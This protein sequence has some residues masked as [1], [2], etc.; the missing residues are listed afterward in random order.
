MKRLLL[1][2]FLIGLFAACTTQKTQEEPY[3]IIVSMDGFRWDYT[4]SVSTPHFDKIAKMGVKA[5]SMKVSFPSKTFPNHYTLVT[6]LVPDNHGIV[7][8]TFYAPEYDEV[9]SI[10][11]REKVQ[12][13]KFYGGEPIW[14]TAEK[15]GVKAASYFWVGSEADIQGIHPSYWKEYDHHFDYYQR[16]DSVIAWLSLEEENRPHMISWYVDQPDGVGHHAGPHSPKADSVIAELDKLLGYFMDRLSNHPLAEHVNVIVT[17]DHGMGNISKEKSIFLKDYIDENWVKYALGGNP[18]WNV[19]A[20]EGFQDSIYLALKNVEGLNIY[21]N[22]DVPKHLHYGKNDR[23]LDFTIVADSSFSVYSDIPKM[24]YSNGTHGYD[25][26]N[27]D[28]N[29]IF[30]AY[31][32]AFKKGYSQAMFSNTSVYPLMC[33]ILGLVP[34]PNDGDFNEVKGMLKNN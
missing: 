5:E 3:L 22:P 19:L 18:I 7:N 24:H 1:F 13:G 26:N 21:K 2:S 33:Q 23:C 9:Y 27:K 11:D 17:A 34:A 4:D 32:P 16:V 8:N 10:R 25:I 28:M 15:Q 14:N 29:A 20:E 30:Y 12:N 6:G 31:G